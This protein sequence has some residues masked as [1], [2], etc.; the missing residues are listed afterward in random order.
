M[1]EVRRHITLLPQDSML[2]DDTIRANIVYGCPDAPDS[3]VLAAAVAADTHSFVS[4]L[5][6]GYDMSRW[7]IAWSGALPSTRAGSRRSVVFDGRVRRGWGGSEPTPGRWRACAGASAVRSPTVGSEVA[8]AGTAQ[9]VSASTT[10]GVWRTPRGSRESGT[11]HS[12]SSRSGTSAE[13]TWG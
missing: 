13:A 2:F 11:R 1:H 5:P 7:P 8:P 6:E 9:A 3:E 12:R 10:A 4:A